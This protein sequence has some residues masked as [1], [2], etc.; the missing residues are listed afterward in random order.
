MRPSPEEHQKT[1]RLYAWINSVS[2][3]QGPRV[4]SE[5]LSILLVFIRSICVLVSQRYTAS[6]PSSALPERMNPA[7][8]VQFFL[9]S[10][11]FS[12][13]RSPGLASSY[14][15]TFPQAGE[16]SEISLAP[17]APAVASSRVRLL[18]GYWDS[19]E[20]SSAFP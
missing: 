19:P 11:C 4:D 5:K 6:L 2:H 15:R 18:H 16:Q 14:L 7:Q 9:I 1:V 12:V 3:P 17:P 13:N 8:Y 20:I 10:P